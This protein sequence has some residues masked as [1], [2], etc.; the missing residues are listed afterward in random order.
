[1]SETR[2]NS[3]GPRGRIGFQKGGI[4]KVKRRRAFVAK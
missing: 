2:G 3:Q 4:A 1:M